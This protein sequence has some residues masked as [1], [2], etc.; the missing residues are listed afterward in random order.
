MSRAI[1]FSVGELLGRNDLNDFY[2]RV[3]YDKSGNIIY[4]PLWVE[5]GEKKVVEFF[6]HYHIGNHNLGVN[7]IELYVELFKSKS[8]LNLLCERADKNNKTILGFMGNKYKQNFWLVKC[9]FCEFEAVQD[10]ST[11][12]RCKNCSILKSR[13]SFEQF[14]KKAIKV[15]GNKYFYG[16]VK[17]SGSKNKVEIFCNDCGNLFYQSPSNHLS[18]NGC[19]ICNESKG[20][21]RVAKYLNK[22]NIKFAK[23]KIFKTLKDKSYLKP[24]FYLLLLNLLIEYDG[25]GH[26]FP[27]FGSTP[28]EKIKNLED[29]QR[30]DKIKDEWASL[31][32][33]PLLRI[34][35]WDFDR[36]EELIEAFILQHSKKEIKQLVLEI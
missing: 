22:N 7:N 12:K 3:E 29:C 21:L 30:R 5:D 13:D 15:H 18:G 16:N 9:D 11:F 23:N 4:T 33:I 31:N 8:N 28:E 35:Y 27:C 26:Y 36:I 32:N 6:C 20:E 1:D 34:P 2:T 10:I 19:P 25:E 24:D 14:E 17:Y